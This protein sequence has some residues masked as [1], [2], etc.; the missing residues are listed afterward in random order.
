[1]GAWFRRRP[2]PPSPLP[3]PPPSS[4]SPPTGILSNPFARF[5]FVMLGVLILSRE[6]DDSCQYAHDGVCDAAARYGQ[7]Q[8]R[9]L[10]ESWTYDFAR[11][12]TYESPPPPPISTELCKFG[13]DATDCGYC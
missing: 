11:D 13:T 1:M 3:P 12:M 9:S 2:P 6:C 8:Q 7:Q 5:V 10:F 4:P